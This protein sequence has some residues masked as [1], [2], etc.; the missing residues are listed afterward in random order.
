MNDKKRLEVIECSI[1][2]ERAVATSLASLLDI[3]L[4][5]SKTLGN[6][7]SSFS[8][9]QKLDLLTDIKV[10]DK[11]AMKKFQIFSEIRNQFA[12]NFDVIDFSSCFLNLDGAEHFLRKNYS[13]ECSD[14]ASKEEEFSTMYSLLF[15][16]ILSITSTIIKQVEK[17]YVRIIVER[18]KEK[19]PGQI[20]QMLDEYLNTNKRASKK[21]KTLIL[22]T[23]QKFDL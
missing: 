6:K 18:E 7:S 11:S 15:A 12:H 19:I 9:K 20:I 13:L 4:D 21:L 16:D 14:G 1:L 22:E 23:K 5:E 2:I 8:F 17:R 10:V 3:D